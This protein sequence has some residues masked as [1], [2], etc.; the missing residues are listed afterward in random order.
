MQFRRGCSIRTTTQ[1]ARLIEVRN[2]ARRTRDREIGAERVVAQRG[3]KEAQKLVRKRLWEVRTRSID[4][5]NRLLIN[6]D[7]KN[8]SVYWDLLKKTVGTKRKKTLIPDEALFDGVVVGGD[9]IL[10][11]WR[12]AFRRLSAVD[13][14]EKRQ[15]E[16]IFGR[17]STRTQGGRA[18]L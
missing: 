13:G 3:L 8:P 14:E 11:V 17:N 1:L 7:S 12:E 4:H 9:N 6:N 16:R 5:R 2:V 10:N 18:Y 15:Q